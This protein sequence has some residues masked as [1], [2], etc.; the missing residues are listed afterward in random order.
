LS[1]CAAISPGRRCVS[2]GSQPMP[3]DRSSTHSRPDPS[4]SVR[5]TLKDAA[6]GPPAHVILKLPLS[7]G[8]P[9]GNNPD[10]R[11]KSDRSRSSV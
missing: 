1:G 5:R 10:R 3:P 8:N 4:R 11:A 9:Y 7:P 6:T 2:S